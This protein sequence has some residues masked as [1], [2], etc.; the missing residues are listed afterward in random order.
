MRF[1]LANLMMFVGLVAVVHADDGGVAVS[2]GGARLI[3]EHPTISMEDEHVRIEM[4]PDRYRVKAV[5]NF[6]NSGS[7]TTTPVG[8][9]IEGEKTYLAEGDKGVFSFRTYVNGKEV[10]T[11][12]IDYD[13]ATEEPRDNHY[14]YFK[15]KEVYFPAYSTT[16]TLVEYTAPYGKGA[17]ANTWVKYDY[18]TGRSWKGP[19][20]KAVFDIGF[21]EDLFGLDME[22]SDDVK[23][24]SRSSGNVVFAMRD[25]KPSVWS[26][27]LINFNKIE[28]CF[29]QNSIGVTC[30]MPYTDLSGKKVR[31]GA[32]I[33]TQVVPTLLV[34]R[35]KRNSVYA[36]HDYRFSDPFLM[37]YFKRYA[38]EEYPGRNTSLPKLT[39]EESALVNSLV[40]MENAVK[41]GILRKAQSAQ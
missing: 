21:S 34:L 15:V 28:S 23:I 13:K 9:P 33:T 40:E 39:P 18:S 8:F 5:F 4:M 20:R 1:L 30:N 25:V 14:K 24:V 7:A 12:D 36:A 26:R 19:I 29:M 17:L 11:K 41:K 16:T 35:L 37:R 27:V 10:Q 6:Y 2:A 38:N 3:S 22:F 32:K 31:F